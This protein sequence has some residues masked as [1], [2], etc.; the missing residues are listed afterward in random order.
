MERL[1]RKTVLPVLVSV[2]YFVSSCGS[3]KEVLTSEQT[4][5]VKKNVQDLLDSISYNISYRGPVAWP[6][7]F[8]DTPNFFMASEGQL[9]FQNLDSARS[10]IN[11]SIAKQIKRIK[12]TWNNIH[13]DVLTDKMAGVGADFHEDITDAEGKSLP[14]DGYF[15]SLVHKS[16][17]GWKLR[18]LHWSIKSNVRK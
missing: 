3:N 8:E 12:L 9:S 5:G 4:A 13:I 18:N 15:T 6:Y 1:F 17:K 10:L 2:F 16:T 7:Y 14:Y 11:N